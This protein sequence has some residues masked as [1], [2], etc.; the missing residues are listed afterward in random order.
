MSKF[1][2]VYLNRLHWHFPNWL[3]F[4]IPGPESS[5]GEMTAMMGVFRSE[6]SNNIIL[7]ESQIEGTI[8]WFLFRLLLHPLT[9][10]SSTDAKRPL[11]SFLQEMHPKHRLQ[12]LQWVSNWFFIS[13]GHF[14]KQVMSIVWIVEVVSYQVSHLCFQV[15]FSLVTDD[16]AV[17]RAKPRKPAT[18]S[19]VDSYVFLAERSCQ[20]PNSLSMNLSSLHNSSWLC[21]N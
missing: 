9:F 6:S 16:D 13:Y 20:S 5:G 15:E 8:F 21:M 19:V 14:K 2:D 3:A 1:Y 4:P 17:V 18:L 7:N 11:L 10:S 12:R